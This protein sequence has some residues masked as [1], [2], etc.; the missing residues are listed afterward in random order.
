M[1]GGLHGLGMGCLVYLCILLGSRGDKMLYRI[2]LRGCFD[3]G[4]HGV[5]C[6]VYLCSGFDS[7]RSRVLWWGWVGSVASKWEA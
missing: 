6:I 5:G 4:T 3:R 1:N 7:M 2:G